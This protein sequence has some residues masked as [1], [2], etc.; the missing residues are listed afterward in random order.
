MIH[1]KTLSVY[2]CISGDLITLSIFWQK[3][4]LKV[5]I[6]KIFFQHWLTS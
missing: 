5:A 4:S 1:S 2:K 6:Q 3:I